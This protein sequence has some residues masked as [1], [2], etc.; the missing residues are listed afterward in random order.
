MCVWYIYCL[1]EIDPYR[2]DAIQHCSDVLMVNKYTEAARW[3]AFYKQPMIAPLACISGPRSSEMRDLSC[4][5]THKQQCIWSFQ[6]EN[7]VI[8]SCAVYCTLQWLKFSRNTPPRCAADFWMPFRQ[9][10]LTQLCQDRSRLI[11]AESQSEQTTQPRAPY[12]DQ[13][14]DH[15]SYLCCSRSGRPTRLRALHEAART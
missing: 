8:S 11:W 10:L 14:R 15:H 13:L 12:P 7:W 2:S 1:G 4:Y 6:A 9:L 5:T 3:P